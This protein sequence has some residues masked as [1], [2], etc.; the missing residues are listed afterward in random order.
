V[1]ALNRR[2]DNHGTGTSGE[3]I[4]RPIGGRE[5]AR[6]LDQHSA[7]LEFY[8]SQWSR[9]PDDCVQEAFVELARQVEKPERPLEWLYRVVRNRAL[10]AARAATRR[11]RHEQ[12]AALRKGATLDPADGLLAADD[13]DSMLRAVERLEPLERELVM[14]RIWGELTWGQVSEVLGV[15]VST[16]QRRYVGALEEMK[17]MLERSCLTKPE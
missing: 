4:G 15:P 2:L 6:L 3:P 17:T 14:L 1:Y 11:D 16:A 10:N 7:A 12:G 9:S 5:I 8:A 13:R